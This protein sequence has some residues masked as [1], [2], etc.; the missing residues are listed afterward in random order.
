MGR[1]FPVKGALPTRQQTLCRTTLA[2]QLGRIQ[3]MFLRCKM[4]CAVKHSITV[5]TLS[6]KVSG[7]YFRKQVWCRWRSDQA[8]GLKTHK[9]K[10]N[11]PIAIFDLLKLIFQRLSKE[12]M[13]NKCVHG[14]TQNANEAFNQFIWN[15]FP[16]STFSSRKIVET[17]VNSSI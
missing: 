12:E 13:L 8:T 3:T 4:L 6:L 5:Q 9:Q 10:L 2:W 14:L 1:G 15:R 11:L 16:K 17:A 7:T